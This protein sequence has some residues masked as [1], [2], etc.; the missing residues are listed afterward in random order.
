[1]LPVHVHRRPRPSD[2]S[3]AHG[4]LPRRRGRF[5]WPGR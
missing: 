5:S 1:V 2:S 3:C 4:W